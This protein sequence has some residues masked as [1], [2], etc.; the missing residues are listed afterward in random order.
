MGLVAPWPVNFPRPGTEPMFPE[1]AGRFLTN[2]PPRKS[3][4][5]KNGKKHFR[6]KKRISVDLY[7]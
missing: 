2:G 5:F 1:L 4:I 6:Q 7:F 3:W